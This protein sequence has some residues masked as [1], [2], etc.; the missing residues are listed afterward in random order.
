MFKIAHLSSF[1]QH[2]GA[3]KAAWRLHDALRSAGHNSKMYVAHKKSDDADVIQVARRSRIQNKLG[4]FYSRIKRTHSLSK[5][6]TANWFDRNLDSEYQWSRLKTLN[7]DVLFVHIT[8]DFLP[9]NVISKIIDSTQAT[10]FFVPVDISAMTGGCHH[11]FDCKGFMAQCGNCPQLVSSHSLDWSNQT[12]R[13]KHKWLANKPINFIAATT[14]VA[15]RIAESSLY[16][17]HPCYQIPLAIDTQTYYPGAK[18]AAREELNLPSAD[19]IIMLGAHSVKDPRK[20]IQYLVDALLILQKNLSADQRAR[21]SLCVVGADSK[22]LLT[23]LD[24][25]VNDLGYVNEERLATAYRA[26]NVFACPSVYDAG[27]MMIPEAMICGT[28][29]VA[30]DSGGAPDIINT[31]QNGYLAQFKSAADLAKGLETILFSSTQKEM[32]VK[33]HK[34]AFKMHHPDA[35]ALQYTQLIEKLK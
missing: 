33:A 25:S 23:G 8:K 27:P 1:D 28:P 15:D 29:V 12:W 21:I 35:V 30:F 10:V 9:V 34:D 31:K 3:A 4:S 18:S 7:I 26:A 32:S 19:L 22:D 14:W 2:Q 5:I 24:F 20:G 17:N 16:R 6:K 11:H 13:E